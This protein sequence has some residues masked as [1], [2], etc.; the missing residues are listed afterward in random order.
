MPPVR[1]SLLA[2]IAAAN[3]S[4]TDVV[5]LVDADAGTPTTYKASVAQL[6]TAVLQGAVGAG[7]GAT[8]Y[9]R[10][11]AGTAPGSGAIRGAL[12]TLTADSPLINS[13]ATWNAAAVTFRH[14]FVNL[15]DTASAAGSCFA[16]FQLAGASK[17]SVTKLGAVVQSG[18]LT[19]TGN[20]TFTGTLGVSGAVT[21]P[22][23]VGALAGNASTAT[24][25]ATASALNHVGGLSTAGAVL[26]GDFGP[27][28]DLAMRPGSATGFITFLNNAGGTI[29]SFTNAGVFS[30]I[31]QVLVNNASA[32]A[33]ALRV[34]GAGVFAGALTVAG[35][36][37]GVTSLSAG[38][39]IVNGMGAGAE[40][41]RV[42]GAA[43]FA[44][45]LTGVTSIAASGSVTVGG[46]LDVAGVVNAGGG[47]SLGGIAV[48]AGDPDTGGFGRR[49]L[50]VPN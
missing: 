23:F 28:K 17:W 7:W 11:G 31:A 43:A 25:A 33:G 21:A 15:T 19:L 34:N 16:D 6:R 39:L 29:G 5:P 37:D 27:T 14:I 2:A 13:T 48:I 1:V 35:A 26:T 49:A 20:S 4:A 10:V 44:G 41:L 18:G 8:D 9:V 42:N 22:S 40:A 24:T 12:G 3:I 30:T 50:T 38:Q 45:S 47:L 46:A 36:V 32:G